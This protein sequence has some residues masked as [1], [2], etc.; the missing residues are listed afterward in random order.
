MGTG[1]RLDAAFQFVDIFRRAPG[2]RG[3]LSRIQDWIRADVSAP[4]YFGSLAAEF[5]LAG[6]AVAYAAAGLVVLNFMRI[7]RAPDRA[8]AEPGSGHDGS[9]LV[10]Q[11]LL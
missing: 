11:Q 4:P 5:H 2:F 9:L 10:Y 6:G 3:I 1:E 8:T 7:A